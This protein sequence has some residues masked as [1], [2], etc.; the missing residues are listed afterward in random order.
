MTFDTFKSLFRTTLTDPRRGGR[1][2]IAL[3]LPMQGLWIAL[4]LM[5]VILSLLVSALFQISPIPEDE[6]GQIIRS[7]PAFQSP[8]LFALINWV[9]SV[10]TVY[11]LH[12][13]S[14]MVGGEGEVRDMLSV[15]IWLQVMTLVLA[16]VFTL[17]SLIIPAIGALCMLVAF[18]WGL[19]AVVAFVDAAADFDSMFRA[20]GVCIA[21]FLAFSFLMTIVASLLAAFGIGAAPNV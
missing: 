19:W 1:D 10:I 17:V 7:S 4:M 6:L 16:V 15:M 12:F 8:I 21:G 2:V 14:R 11:V 20:L 9:Q 18:F 3:N 5:A 13:V